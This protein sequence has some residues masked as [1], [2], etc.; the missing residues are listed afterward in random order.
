MSDSMRDRLHVVVDQLPSARLADVL[1]FVEL[2]VDSEPDSEVDL[3]EAWMLASGAF[4]VIIS[5]D[6]NPPTVIRT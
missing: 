2:L 3:E 6:G 5:D 4:R 1:Q